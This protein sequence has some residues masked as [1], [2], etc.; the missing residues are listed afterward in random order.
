MDLFRFSL[1]LSLF[2]I[3]GCTTTAPTYVVSIPNIQKL[4]DAGS[5]KVAVTKVE[6]PASKQE[7]LNTVGLR[8]STMLSPYDGSYGKYLREALR[9]EFYEA[10]RLAETSNVQ[11]SGVLLKN[12]VDSTGI[13]IGTALIEAQF[14]VQRDKQVTYDKTISANHEWESSFAGAIAIPAAINNYSTTV[15]KLLN[16]L[17]TDKA[18]QDAIK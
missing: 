11:L 16:Q 2:A 18:F 8:G 9:A 17:Y 5:S 3:A 6:V 13:N 15:Q 12:D 4:R 10:G 7:Q 1:L 14:I